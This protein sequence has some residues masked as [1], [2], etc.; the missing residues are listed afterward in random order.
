MP[1]SASYKVL[2]NNNQD[3]V[4]IIKADN[5][6]TNGVVHVIDEVMFI[7]DLNAKEIVGDATAIRISAV[8]LSLMCFV[9]F[10]LSNNS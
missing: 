6:V 5:R 9:A 1:I 2:F 3:V 7:D 8:T 4:Q 10:L